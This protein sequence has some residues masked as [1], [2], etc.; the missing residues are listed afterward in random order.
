MPLHVL[1]RCDSILGIHGDDGVFAY[2]TVV[3]REH[4]C[5]DGASRIL[6]NGLKVPLYGGT[7][8]SVDIIGYWGFGEHRQLCPV[9]CGSKSQRHIFPLCF[10]IALVRPFFVRGYVALNRRNGHLLAVRGHR[11]KQSPCKSEGDIQ[12]KD[13]R[14]ECKRTEGIT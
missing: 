13:R 9:L 1:L 12:R 8:V 3:L 2:I 6:G 10:V 14:R 7:A 11:I 5:D 4:T